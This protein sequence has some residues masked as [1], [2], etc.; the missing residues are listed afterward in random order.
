VGPIK[1]LV[2]SHVKASVLLSNVGAEVSFQLPSNA[3]S[4]FKDMLLEMDHRKQ[5]LGINS[6]GVSVTTLEEVFLKVASDAAE[7]KKLGHLGR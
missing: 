1:A 2:R 4:S 6:Y 3:S 7:H 5:E